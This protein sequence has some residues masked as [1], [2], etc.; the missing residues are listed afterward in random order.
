[1]SV[2]FPLLFNNLKPKQ[3]KLIK[4]IANSAYPYDD[5]Y[6]RIWGDF[7][8]KFNFL[9]DVTTL[10][11]SAV[12]SKEITTSFINLKPICMTV[13]FNC[14]DKITSYLKTL[15]SNIDPEDKFIGVI[16]AIS[17]GASVNNYTSFFVTEI[18]VNP[19]RC[20]SNDIT[21]YTNNSV[22][23][24]GYTFYKTNQSEPMDFYDEDCSDQ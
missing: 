4:D 6:V 2:H 24:K 16:P 18:N 13:I 15:I 20:F 14:D 21:V 19:V 17:I 11:I 10:S 1:M 7:L 22:E 23:I 3:T 9:T 12:E 8:S 5:V